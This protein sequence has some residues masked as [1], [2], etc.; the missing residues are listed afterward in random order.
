MES[1]SYEA[2]RLAD[3]IFQ[4]ML[5]ACE[6]IISWNTGVNNVDDYLTTPEGVQKMAASCMMIETIG[7]ELKKIEKIIPGFLKD[8]EPDYPW[9]SYMGLR[10]R[11]AHG[12]FNLDEEIIFD[13]AKN[14]IPEMK[15]ILKR[16]KLRLEEELL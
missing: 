5:E 10:D 6:L 8:N 2:I 7:E 9:K 16:L 13:V 3:H 15:S 12:Y 14:E 1:P 11:I 4:Q